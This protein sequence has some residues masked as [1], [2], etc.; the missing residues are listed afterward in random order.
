MSGTRCV[1]PPLA[2]AGLG[3][4]SETARV[5]GIYITAAEKATESES[6]VPEEVEE[7]DAGQLAPQPEFFKDDPVRVALYKS[8]LETRNAWVE[9]EKHT[10]RLRD[11]FTDLYTMNHEYSQQPDAL[12]IVIGMVC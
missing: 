4:L 9:R 2:A 11:T 10:E 3:E 5:Q 8:W 6:E 7:K 12:E 1:A